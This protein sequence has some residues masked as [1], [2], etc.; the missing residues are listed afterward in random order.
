MTHRRTR[1]REKKPRKSWR[2]PALIG[3]GVLVATVGAVL[4]AVSLGGGDQTAPRTSDAPATITSLAG[5]EVVEPSA[6][7]GR[8]PLDVPVSHNFVLK[9][10]SDRPVD[11]GVPAIEVLDGC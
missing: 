4:V 5:V 8:R 1:Q 3:G 2:W 11:L 9:N 6:D 7:L 10:N